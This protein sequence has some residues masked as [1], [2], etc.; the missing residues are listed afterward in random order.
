MSDDDIMGIRERFANFQ[1]FSDADCIKLAAAEAQ[2]YGTKMLP[3][4]GMLKWLHKAGVACKTP[5][6]DT[7]WYGVWRRY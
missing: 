2:I 7:C 6:F 3:A 4:I 1:E 5:P